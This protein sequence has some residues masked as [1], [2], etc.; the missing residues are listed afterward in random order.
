MAFKAHSVVFIFLLLAGCGA[1]T[2][3]E[4][5]EGSTGAGKAPGAAIAQKTCPVMGNPIDPEVFVDYKGRRIYFCCPG[6]DKTFQKD[7]EKYLA[8]V[9][10]EIQGGG[11][12]REA[13]AGAI[14]QKNCPLTGG[15]INPDIHFDYNGRRIYFCCPGCIENFKKDPVKYLAKVDAEIQAAGGK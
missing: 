2:A 8:K 9:D 14:A 12:A 11:P 7:P 1:G 15:R 4:A 6:C 3:P 10:A 5:G 13:P